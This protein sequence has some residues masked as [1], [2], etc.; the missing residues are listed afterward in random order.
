MMCHH[1]E[2]TRKLSHFK[3]PFVRGSKWRIYT[4]MLLRFLIVSM[5]ITLQNTFLKIEND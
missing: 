5:I 3:A 1:K 2:E 4:I